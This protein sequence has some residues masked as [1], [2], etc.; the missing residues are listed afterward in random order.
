LLRL[1]NNIKMYF[2]F[3]IFF[4]GVNIVNKQESGVTIKTIDVIQLTTKKK[5]LKILERKILKR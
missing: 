4:F 1:K 2:V 5:K 3:Y